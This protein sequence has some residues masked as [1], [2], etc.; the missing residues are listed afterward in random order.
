MIFLINKVY[1]KFVNFIKKNYKEILFLIVFYIVM[2][3]PLPYYI[4][5]SGGTIDVGDR[6]EV[7]KGYS[8][9]GS[10]NLAYVS[11]LR[12]TIPTYLLSYIIPSWERIKIDSYQYNE[13][14]TIEDI[15][16]RD[17]LYLK[18][19]NQSAIMV[20]YTKAGRSFEI[21]KH[22]YFVYFVDERANNKIKVGDEVV[23]VDHLEKVNLDAFKQYIST[24]SV[25][26]EVTIKLKRGKEDLE[27]K[28]TVF[29]E[30]GTKYAGLAFFDILDYE[31]NPKLTLKFKPSETGPS[32]GLTLSLA[33]YNQLVEEDITKGRKIVGTGTIDKDGK[34]GEIGGVKY[35]LMGA[36]NKK[37]D[38]FLV[39]NGENYKECIKLQKEK[40]YK[41]KI[42]GVSTFDEALE[43]LKEVN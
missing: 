15:T 17:K 33:I 26:D 36:V 29:E 20:S 12:G 37:A 42:I 30:E 22:H 8:E 6:L 34:V 3:F 7:E 14:E 18:D 27:I 43:K 31:I 32:G 25:G 9:E 19:A 2:T 39:P 16:T 41:I 1:E 4:C 35:K 24:K 28:T 5:V 10:F 38:I 21:K 13:E 11:E 40:G 23:G